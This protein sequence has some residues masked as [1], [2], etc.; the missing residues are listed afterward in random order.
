MAQVYF[1][2]KTPGTRPLGK[3]QLLIG[4]A[5]LLLGLAL[6]FFQ[7][8]G[9][10]AQKAGITSETA[11]IVVVIS[12]A[13]VLLAVFFISKKAPK[14]MTLT[15]TSD[16]IGFYNS[17]Y[18]VSKQIFLA[19]PEVVKIEEIDSSPDRFVPP[20]NVFVGVAN[21][22]SSG[23]AVFFSIKSS[24]DISMF[25]VMEARKS[26]FLEALQAAGA[27]IKIS[28]TKTNIFEVKKQEEELRKQR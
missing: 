8:Q 5:L 16:G 4:A 20:A 6:V 2:Q 13:L 14:E 26:E 10:R 19:W 9:Y 24:K 25:F 1:E 28:K 23:K 7:L 3:R 21:Q 11:L 27:G 17:L 22:L 12:G 18:L 15:V